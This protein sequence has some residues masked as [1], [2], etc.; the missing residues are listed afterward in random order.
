MMIRIV[1]IALFTLFVAYSGII[2]LQGG[3]NH[4]N[5]SKEVL[6]GMQVWQNKNCQSCHQ[7]Y[8]LGGYLGPDLTNV[9]SAPGKGPEYM[10]GLIKYGTGRMP[11]FHLSDKET[12]QLISFLA[13]VDES[14]TPAV[15]SSAVHWTGTY[16][17]EEQK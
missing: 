10:K 5:R 9:H 1:W 11:N 8:G 7:L 6:E 17:I 2:Y 14:G 16:L 12:D 3:D 4:G 15:P 13:W